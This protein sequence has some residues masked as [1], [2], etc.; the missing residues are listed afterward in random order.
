MSL[1]EVVRQFGIDTTGF[2]TTSDTIHMDDEFI[3]QRVFRRLDETQAAQII[4]SKVHNKDSC[5]EVMVREQILL[6][7]L[8]L[9]QTSCNPESSLTLD[10]I[11]IEG[12]KYYI[13]R[14][15]KYTIALACS[16]RTIISVTAMGV[17]LYP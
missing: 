13:T 10:S 4:I 17:Q 15:G 8:S 3:E 9:R 2:V 1:D 14:C 7:G 16:N 6:E 11:T 12:F 5:E